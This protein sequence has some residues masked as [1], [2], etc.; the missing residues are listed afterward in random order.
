M[1][2]VV[3]CVRESDGGRLV[4]NCEYHMDFFR[5]HHTL[6]RRNLHKIRTSLNGE[7]QL[8]S[9][10]YFINSFYL[11]VCLFNLFPFLFHN[12]KRWLGLGYRPLLFQDSF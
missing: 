10:N 1:I 5:A 7:P 6:S 8:V 4:R 11:F 3:M 9:L 12:S 2:F